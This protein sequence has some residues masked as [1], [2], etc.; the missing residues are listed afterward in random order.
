[1][2]TKQKYSNPGTIAAL[3]AIAII[4]ACANAVALYALFLQSR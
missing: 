2:T 1:M 3:V 4:L